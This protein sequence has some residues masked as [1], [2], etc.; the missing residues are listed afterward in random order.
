MPT[1]RPGR[2]SAFVTATLLALVAGRSLCAAG[3]AP[4]TVMV[5]MGDGVKLA[6]DVYLPAKGGPP[7]ST[8]LIRTPYGKGVGKGLAANFGAHGY[9]VV[10]QDMRGRFASEG[11][12]AII[13]GNDGLGDRHRDGHDTIRWVSGQPWSDGKVATWGGSALAIVQNM[14]APDA[15]A[16]L[17]GQVVTMAFSDYYHQ[18]AYQGGVWRKE[19][20][21]GWLKATTMEEVNLAT[22]LEHPTY[23]DFWKRLSAEAHADRVNA[24]GVFIGGWY[25]IFQQGTINSFVTVQNRGGPA[26][27]GKCFL[28]IGPLAHGAFNQKVDYPDAARAPINAV[29]TMNL[30]AYWLK[31]ERNGVEKLKAVHYYVMGDTEDKTAPGNF[32]RSAD[33]WPPPAHV[34]P[35]YFHADHSLSGEKPGGGERLAYSY[36]PRDPVPTVGGQNLLIAKGPADQR[37]AESRSDVLS[38]TTRA[39]PEPLEVTGRITAKLF[40]SSDC[41]DTDFT[42]KL[43][44]VYPDGRSMLVTDGIQRASVR[45]DLTNC[46]PLEP[47]KVYELNVDLWSTSLVFA[48]GHSIRVAVSSSNSPRFEP[49]ANTGEPHPSPGKSRVATNTLHLSAGRPSHI[50]L[51]LYDGP[52]A[53]VGTRKPRVARPVKGTK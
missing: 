40:V 45:N 42:V 49:N 50:L 1:L 12:H 23:D 31:G 2:P 17:K 4:Q 10:V 35:F 46:E 14:A 33:A 27:R 43:C 19:M 32:W 24:P 8:I 30:L 21:E 11:H 44:D 5:P 25:D 16:A 20:I 53:V 9:A 48:K 52:D 47:G 7:Y 28:V 13:F 18:A 38:F 3:P 29:D 41:P 39:L 15:P 22:F 26:A 6:T 34:A 51:P 36:D 37:P